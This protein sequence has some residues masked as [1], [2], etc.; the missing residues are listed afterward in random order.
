MQNKKIQLWALGIACYNCSIEYIAGT[1]K[2]CADLLSKK[3][4][5]DDSVTV[6]RTVEP[7][8]NDNTF[9]VGAINLIA[10]NPNFAGC[11]M[12]TRDNLEVQETYLN[13]LDM[14]QEQKKYKEIM[15]L[16]IFWNTVTPLGQ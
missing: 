12:P 11:D 10:I 4:D 3:P 16:K 13:G 9:E 1:E 14:V 6:T 8:F 2:I 5:A 7:D 15:E